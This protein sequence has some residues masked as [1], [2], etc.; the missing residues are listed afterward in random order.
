MPS[1]SNAHIILM[2]IFQVS[3]YYKSRTVLY[4]GFSRNDV[5]AAI[6]KVWCHFR[7]L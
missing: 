7:T 1:I 6:I 5:M 4:R 3:Q 2:A